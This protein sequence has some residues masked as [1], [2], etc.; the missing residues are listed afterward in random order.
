[1]LINCSFV[2]DALFIALFRVTNRFPKKF[3]EKILF[4]NEKKVKNIEE[5]PYEETIVAI[6]VDR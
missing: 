1:M 3:Y 5:P 2:Q 6:G 4:Q